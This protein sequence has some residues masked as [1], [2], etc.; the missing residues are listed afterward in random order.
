VTGSLGDGTADAGK[1]AFF[2][3]DCGFEGEIDDDYVVE[4]TEAA[5]RYYCPRCGRLLADR[6]RRSCAA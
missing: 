3:H 6:P 1:S 2:C 4:P 5:V